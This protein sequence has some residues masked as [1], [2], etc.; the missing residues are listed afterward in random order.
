MDRDQKGYISASDVEGL[1]RDVEKIE[2]QEQKGA[3]MSTDE[4]H[5]MIETTNKLFET[6]NSDTNENQNRLQPS[7]F[8]K[9][10]SPSH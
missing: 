1:G 3:T 2:Y 6:E 9:I 10:F 7:V 4:A 5:D 8:G